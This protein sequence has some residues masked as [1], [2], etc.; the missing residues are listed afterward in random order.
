MSAL[1]HL[2]F[3][4]KGGNL[5][6]ML[7]NER[8]QQVNSGITKAITKEI[9]FPNDQIT[10]N[11]HLIEQ[12]KTQT[13][14]NSL[15]V[16]RETNPAD[17]AGV[18]NFYP[19]QQDPA[20]NLGFTISL[21]GMP[22]SGRTTTLGYIQ[23]E[24]IDELSINPLYEGFHIV[25]EF[26][27]SIIQDLK[28]EEDFSYTNLYLRQQIRSRLIYK[29]IYEKDILPRVS[30][31]ERDWTDL[32]FARANFMYGRHEGKVFRTFEET[33]LANLHK[34]NQ[35]IRIIVNTLISPEM[36]FSRETE[37]KPYHT[38]VKP[39]FL[40]LLYEQYLRFHYEAVNFEKIYGEPRPFIYACIDTEDS[41]I[42]PFEKICYL[43]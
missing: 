34:Y 7:D 43:L 4:G 10:R 38:I 31:F 11:L 12:Y 29:S 16:N 33:F 8:W 42:R 17:L 30:V 35:S 40:N 27:G 37:D 14:L 20:E 24:Y 23:Q 26:I 15:G 1:Y 19:L 3:L 39:E 22:N 18:N 6:E 2:L 36:S 9:I 25:P 5:A 13:A 28:A 21:I 41:F 32:P